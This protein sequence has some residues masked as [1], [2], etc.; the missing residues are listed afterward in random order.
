MSNEKE[1]QSL[2]D[3]GFV[4]LRAQRTTNAPIGWKRKLSPTNKVKWGYAAEMADPLLSV[5]HS[6]FNAAILSRSHC[7]FYLGWGNLCC[8]D[9]DTKKIDEATTTAL[10]NQIIKKLGANVVVEQTK[11]NG[12][13]IYFLYE[14]RLDNIPDWTGQ[15]GTN[16]IEMYYSKRFIACYLSNSKKY[17]LE[18][19][20]LLTLK[21]LSSTQHKALLTILA[22]YKGKKS[23]TR[24]QSSTTPI[25]DETW[26]QAEAY[27]KQ[28][29]EKELDVTGD[30]PEWFKIGKGFANAFGAKGFDMFNRLSQF[31]PLYNADTIETDYGNFCNGEK[32][33]PKKKLTIATFF[34]ICEDN[35][36]LDL[37]TL[38]TLKLNPPAS[39]KE[40]ELTLTKKERMPE[41]VHKLVSAF[42]QHV[43]ICCIDQASF[44][45][46]EQTHW[47]KRNA[48]FV[49][50][51]INNF[52]DRSD[53]EDRYRNLLRTVPYLKMAIEELKLTTM[54]EALEPRT[55]N[56]HDGVF[57]NLENGVL[58]INIKTGKRKL[59]DHESSYNFTTLLPYCYEPATTCPRFD[60]WL[61]TQV[62]DTTLHEA[63]FAFVASCLTKHKADIIM[64]LVG[65][66]STGKSSLIEITRRVIGLD[67]AVA[68]SA[69]ILFGGTPEAQTQ[70]MMMENKLLA[71]DFDSQ[72]FKHLEM[73]LKVAAQ[74]PLPG[75]QMHVTRRPVINYGRLL[76]AMNRYSYSV[77]N[78]AVARRLITIPMDVQVKKD[79]TIMP[80]IYDNELAGIFNHVVNDGLKHLIENGGQIHITDAMRQATVDFHM[81]ERDSVRWFKDNYTVPKESSDKSN[82][83]T[84]KQKLEKAN[85]ELK[86]ELFTVSEM[87]KKFKDY[88]TDEE[89]MPEIRVQM[90]KH[91]AQD[92]KLIGI[93]DKVYKTATEKTDWGIYLHKIKQ[94]EKTK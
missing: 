74:E 36:L 71:Y 19:G 41:H 85:D 15:N 39:V 83:L 73:L 13:H 9:L 14:Q 46:F 7:G 42:V 1:I 17:K 67:N 82:R 75:W 72:P 35:G 89:N 24:K 37:N 54:R 26:E 61:S 47:V 87:Y 21:P 3:Q 94:D 30:N 6:T 81:R 91:F 76:V 48:K 34:K 40:F 62:P 56:L 55:G 79:N 20:S 51:L 80:A 64:L 49:V 12:Y 16:W 69:G 10:K 78:P 38:Q 8:I 29:E 22:P 2:H 70:A 77:F 11:S 44:F 25:D 66:T 63:Y 93:E 50:D 28:I 18:H 90:R 33:P 58:H 4:I 5:Y 86:I 43:E 60:T 52:V 27:V 53:V 23:A 84:A 57:I 59:L 45:I 32:N 92:L 68:V 31:S 65:D 88:M